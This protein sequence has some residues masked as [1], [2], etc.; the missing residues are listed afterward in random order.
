MKVTGSL[1]KMSQIEEKVETVS[2]KGDMF[3]VSQKTDDSWQKEGRSQGA[4]SFPGREKASLKAKS[5][6]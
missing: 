3:S 5:L 4:K 6:W 1:L 2:Q